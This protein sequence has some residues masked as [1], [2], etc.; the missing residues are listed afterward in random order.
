M[1]RAMIMPRPALAPPSLTSEES[2]DDHH[3]GAAAS[4][5]PGSN[6]CDSNAVVGYGNPKPNY[7]RAMVEL[8]LEEQEL[9]PH[10][11]VGRANA[12]YC[13]LVGSIHVTHTAAATAA[14]YW[15]GVSLVCLTQQLIP[16]YKDR[17]YLYL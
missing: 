2:D 11:E 14:F 15:F 4:P 5:A 16:K 13:Q 7:L 9:S 3:P 10:A 17:L 8:G 1:S 12:S 6:W